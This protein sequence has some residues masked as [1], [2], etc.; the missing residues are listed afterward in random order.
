ME[1]DAYQIFTQA[2]RIYMRGIRGAIAERLGS[3]PVGLKILTPR[4][5]DSQ[6]PSASLVA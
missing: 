3:V 5:R 6:M 2:H 4:F 1:Q